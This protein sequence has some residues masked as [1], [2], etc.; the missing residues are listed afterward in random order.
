MA[1]LV[2]ESW[3]DDFGGPNDDAEQSS[4][5]SIGKKLVSET[6]SVWDEEFD[7]NEQGSGSN[8]SESDSKVEEEEN[9]DDLFE[10]DDSHSQPETATSSLMNDSDIGEVSASSISQLRSVFSA[11]EGESDGHNS[12]C[13]ASL[14]K[15]IQRVEDALSS[16]ATPRDPGAVPESELS[17]EIRSLVLQMETLKGAADQ[18]K[19]DKVL[20]ELAVKCYDA[21]DYTR[22]AQYHLTILEK[23]DYFENSNEFMYIAE[24]LVRIWCCQGKFSFGLDKLNAILQGHLYPKYKKL[25]SDAMDDLTLVSDAR[26]MME[27]I[28]TLEL[29][30]AKLCLE[31]GLPEYASQILLRLARDIDLDYAPDIDNGEAKL[32]IILLWLAESYIQARALCRCASVLGRVKYLRQNSYLGRRSR[33][34]AD[35]SSLFRA[36]FEPVE[37]PNFHRLVVRYICLEEDIKTAL[38]CMAGLQQY[39]K[40][41]GIEKS[42]YTEASDYEL[43]GDILAKAASHG[44]VRSKFPLVIRP[45]FEKLGVL[46]FVVKNQEGDVKITDGYILK[47]K[48][49][50]VKACVKYFRLAYDIYAAAG[51]HVPATTMALKIAKVQT[52]VLF[53]AFLPTINGTFL[54]TL[55]AGRKYEA[56]N[57]TMANTSMKNILYAFDEIEHPAN[58]AYTRSKSMGLPLAHVDSCL[59]LSE[60]S[61]M[62][63]DVGQSSKYWIEACDLFAYLLID[64]PSV[65]LVRSVSFSTSEYIMHLFARIIA[66]F[67]AMPK[68]IVSPYVYLID[69][70]T[71]AQID[72]GRRNSFQ[73]KKNAL[74]PIFQYYHQDKQPLTFRGK[75]GMAQGSTP[76]AGDLSKWDVLAKTSDADQLTTQFCSGCLIRIKRTAALLSCKKS[77]REIFSASIRDL[78]DWAHAMV[79]RRKRSWQPQA[80]DLNYGTI[81]KKTLESAEYSRVT[82]QLQ[83]LIYVVNMKNFIGIFSPETGKRSVLLLSAK[84]G[85][86]IVVES[87]GGG[88]SPKRH[89]RAPSIDSTINEDNTYSNNTVT[90]RGNLRKA[91][92]RRVMVDARKHRPHKSAASGIQCVG[93]D[94]ERNA[95]E[96]AAVLNLESFAEEVVREAELL[97]KLQNVHIRGTDP[98]EFPSFKKPL[99]WPWKWI[100]KRVNVPNKL[101]SLRASHAPII[102]VSSP[103]LSLFPLEQAVVKVADSCRVSSLLFNAVVFMRDNILPSTKA[104]QL[105]LPRM[106]GFLSFSY[107]TRRPLR[108]R[109]NEQVRKK[110]MMRKMFTALNHTVQKV[111]PL[112]PEP[113]EVDGP[114]ITG[115]RIVEEKQTFFSYLARRSEPHSDNLPFQSP[116]LS[117]GKS[118]LSKRIKGALPGL[119]DFIYSDDSL[120]SSSEILSRLDGPTNMSDNR[121][122]FVLLTFADLLEYGEPLLHI[123]GFRPDIQFLYV[124]HQHFETATHVLSDVFS[125]VSQC[126]DHDKKL[127]NKA[128]KSS[129]QAIKASDLNLPEE[130]STLFDVIQST[131]RVLLEKHNIETV[132]FGNSLSQSITGHLP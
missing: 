62:N 42:K 76:A 3:D 49:S 27:N 14:L 92:I 56:P 1:S 103:I 79:W 101:R 69:V 100:Y 70:Y 102:F 61:Y 60:Y 45:D 22:A 20:R 25:R 19:F 53:D 124:S 120:S 41:M 39:E 123:I 23:C 6:G 82:E 78:G 46:D 17:D 43:Y 112:I 68:T 52:S 75:N 9:W 80:T 5:Q 97:Q 36:L 117:H 2:E 94:E 132:Y 37:A 51:D 108:L 125:C 128:Q 59:V 54:E 11:G 57:V 66:I 85:S 50:V 71:H 15:K 106:P 65:P 130:W 91:I 72:A 118:N 104:T 110:K 113:D 121:V 87:D 74:S 98:S 127:H 13:G 63:G 67:F 58:L 126:V 93:T 29:A 7:F 90:L 122:P 44:Y 81:Y 24:A 105:V 35:G 10:E 8:S 119:F 55:A 40:L 64:G 89:N 88:D 16:S 38:C 4:R 32:E 21:R 115:A 73:I 84:G 111:D 83:R 28:Q 48:H 96:L 95:Q 109:T 31:A 34:S 114:R 30:R 77:P 116:L 33:R 26:A 12:D 99:S 131:R 86:P 129:K 107:L 47:T 18:G